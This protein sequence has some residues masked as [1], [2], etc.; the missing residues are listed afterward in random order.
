MTKSSVAGGTPADPSLTAVGQESS[1]GGESCAASEVTRSR[2]S[3]TPSATTG[4]VA[5]VSWVVSGHAACVTTVR[6]VTAS[7]LLAVATTDH[8]MSARPTAGAE[9]I[10]L[11]LFST[12]RISQV[13]T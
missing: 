5:T 2:T 12:V 13:E 3:A 10:H 8:V 11:S 4:T 7:A 6:I 1:T 9:K